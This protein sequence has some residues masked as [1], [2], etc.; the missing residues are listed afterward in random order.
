MSALAG[1]ADCSHWQRWY[2]HCCPW[3]SAH[4]SSPSPVSAPPLFCLQ[5]IPYPPPP[6]PVPPQTPNVN[7]HAGHWTPGVLLG[8]LPNDQMDPPSWGL[9]GVVS[10]SRRH[11][12]THI[13]VWHA[14]PVSDWAA[15]LPLWG[16][17]GPPP[18]P[19]VFTSRPDCYGS[20][21]QCRPRSCGPRR[22]LSPNLL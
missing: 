6:L 3:P 16:F 12:Q 8:I 19:P 11:Q 5:G 1:G 21:A 2:G 13:P 7:P 20:G 10:G 15:A 14:A 18:T 9:S 4:T 17:V 22:P